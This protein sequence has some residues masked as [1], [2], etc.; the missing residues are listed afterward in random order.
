MITKW[1]VY[2]IMLFQ[3]VVVAIFIQSFDWYWQSSLLNKC[4]SIIQIIAQYIL[5]KMNLSFFCVCILGFFILSQD[6]CC[7]QSLTGKADIY[8]VIS[9]CNQFDYQFRSFYYKLGGFLL[10]C[11]DNSVI[12]KQPASFVVITCNWILETEDYKK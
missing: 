6:W 12:N 11:V 7:L 5:L 1:L 3:A 8:I 10:L 4:Q 9:C 2:C